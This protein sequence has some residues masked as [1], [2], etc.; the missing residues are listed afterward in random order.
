MQKPLIGITTS[1]K[2]IA[3]LPD[4]KRYDNL[5]HDEYSLAI[6]RAGGMPLL[7]PIDFPLDDLPHLLNKLQGVLLSGGGDIY[8]E[9]YGH[10]NDGYSKNK[11]RSRDTLEKKLAELAIAR[12]LPLLGIC[13][14]HQMLNVTS[15]GTLYTDIGNQYPTEIKHQRPEQ[16]E[17][18]RVVH[19]VD[20]VKGSRLASIIGKQ[21]LGVNSRHHQ[22]IHQVAPEFIVTA[23]SIDGLIEGI[24]HPGQRFCMGVQWHPESLPEMDDH[25]AIFKAFVTAA[26]D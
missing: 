6:S 7:I 20:I 18:G 24:E 3:G 22:A 19:E 21:S 16:P 1:R 26:M 17:R 25:R 10:E 14:G 2:E 8:P 12:D 4:Y 15:G 11:S 23:C 9:L 13:R 5:L